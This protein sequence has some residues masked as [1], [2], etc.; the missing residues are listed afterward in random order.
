MASLQI[1]QILKEY[2]NIINI[3][4]ANKF[5]NLDQMSVNIFLGPKLTQQNHPN[6]PKANSRHIKYLLPLEQRTQ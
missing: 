4:N 3:F 6:Q 2:T 1:V 5:S